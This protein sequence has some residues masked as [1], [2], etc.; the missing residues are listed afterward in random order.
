MKH[1][2]GIHEV[3]ID[4]SLPDLSWWVILT[5]LGLLNPYVFLQTQI[6][7]YSTS[8]LVNSKYPGFE[9]SS[10]P[11]Q[12]LKEEYFFISLSLA[13]CLWYCL[14]AVEA[15]LPTLDAR[16]NCCNMPSVSWAIKCIIA[17]IRKDETTFFI[18]SIRIVV[19]KKKKKR[20]SIRIVHAEWFGCVRERVHESM[21]ISHKKKTKIVNEST[22][23][24]RKVFKRFP[25]HLKSRFFFSFPDSAPREILETAP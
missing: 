17:S 12:L 5:T 6:H 13:S 4:I 10:G 8:R 19:F 15:E 16:L 11:R 14:A 22:K 2:N 3:D 18:Q 25:F 21:G 23:E 1:K 20:K 9:I 7:K 24:K